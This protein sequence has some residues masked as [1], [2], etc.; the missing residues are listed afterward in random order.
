MHTSLNIW[1]FCLLFIHFKRIFQRYSILIKFGHMRLLHHFFTSFMS[2][3]GMELIIRSWLCRV[4]IWYIQWTITNEMHCIDET[5]YCDSPFKWLIFYCSC[6]IVR[7][8]CN[9]N[10]FS[11]FRMW[12]NNWFKEEKSRF[13]SE[14]SFQR[15]QSLTP[16]QR[17]KTKSRII[18]VLLLLSFV[19]LLSIP[20]LH[21]RALKWMRLVLICLFAGY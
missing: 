12:T 17:P 1:I 9:K 16:A 2:Q 15:L 7:Y 8:N 4:I 10:M 18:I 19:C 14:I 5:E 21:L 13:Y 3:L 20:S 6:S 11:L